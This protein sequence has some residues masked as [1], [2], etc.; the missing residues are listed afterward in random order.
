MEQQED[1]GRNLRNQVVC[2]FQHDYKLEGICQPSKLGSL[3]NKLRT[4]I[5]NYL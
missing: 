5:K 1:C 4:F 3:I 2:R